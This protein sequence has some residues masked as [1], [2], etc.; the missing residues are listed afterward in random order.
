MNEKLQ[1][2]LENAKSFFVLA[3]LLIVLAGFLFATGGIAYQSNLKTLEMLHQ[4]TEN[5][6]STFYMSNNTGFVGGPLK[7]YLEAKF[8]YG[9]SLYEFSK[10]QLELWKLLFVFGVMV[11]LFSILYWFIGK[12]KIKTLIKSDNWLGTKKE[13]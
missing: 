7:N 13:R 11:T 8:K 10:T 1:I 3:Q 4:N 12:R 2:E 9:E 6:L 5:I